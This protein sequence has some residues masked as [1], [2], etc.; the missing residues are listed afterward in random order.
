[1]EADLIAKCNSQLGHM[2]ACTVCVLASMYPC[3][4]ICTYN[5]TCVHVCVCMYVSKH[6]C[7]YMYV[8]MYV[9][10]YMYVRIYIDVKAPK[11]ENL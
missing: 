1:M 3:M 9:Q 4:H 5:C 8:S 10:L 7:I 2:Y 6:L 11:G